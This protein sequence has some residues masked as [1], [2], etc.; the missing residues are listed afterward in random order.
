[1]GTNEEGD[2]DLMLQ[3]VIVKK[4]EN[5]KYHGSLMNADGNSEEEIR[6]IQVRWMSW[7]KTLRCAV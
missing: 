5:F 7:R 2:D 1:M 6:R 4:V 3:G